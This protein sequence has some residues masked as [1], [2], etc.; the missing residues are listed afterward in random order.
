M[1]VITASEGQKCKER[2]HF[3]RHGSAWAGWRRLSVFCAA[4]A[5]VVAG[6][7]PAQIRKG[8][9]KI[10]LEPVAS[11]L[12]APVHLTH[13]GDGSGRLFIVDQAGSIRIVKNGKLL[14]KPFLDLTDEIPELSP[15]FDERGV[16]GMAFHPDYAKNGRF[17]VRYSQARTF[18]PSLGRCIGGSRGC[19]AE[20]LAEFSVS[21][22]PDVANPDGKILFRI[23][24]PE[25]NHDAG[26]VAFGPDGF[27]YFTLGDGGGANDDLHRPNLP[28]TKLGNGQNIETVLGAMLRIDVN[29][30]PPYTIP[31]DNPFVEKAGVDEIYAYGFRNPYRFSFDDGPGGDGRLLVADVGQNLFEELDVVVKGGNY[32]WAIR[33]GK[34]CFDPF[35]PREPPKECDTEGLIDPIVDYTHEDGGISIIGG[36]VYRGTR[37]PDLKAIYVFGDFSASFGEPLGRLY[38]L[39]E[40]EPEKFEILEFV[41]SPND[42][43]YGLFLKG[44]GEDED[45]EVYV[46]GSTELAP[47][48]D[49]GV[50]ERVVVVGDCGG[51]EKIKSAKC[52]ARKGN[53]KMTVKLLKG[54]PREPFMVALSTGQSEHGTLDD[55]GKGMAK[56]KNL[57]GGDGSAEATFGCGAI[58]M[59]DYSCP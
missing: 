55:Q 6:Q 49:T 24:E 59:K 40:P 38:H 28:H 21:Q 35:N 17:F 43:P 22:N 18:G 53:N 10:W 5:L 30:D 4:V 12:A 45:G 7:A 1:T 50:V 3:P 27:L 14:G 39:A 23:D 2:D 58:E 13:A 16:L 29:G 57:L 47:I 19:H 37:S 54:N 9:I 42:R 52:K 25:F 15:G 8:D 34:H 32:G 44:F 56:F 20:V 11:G 33:E 36:Y 26:T 31:S 51:L 48:G 46:L 41:I